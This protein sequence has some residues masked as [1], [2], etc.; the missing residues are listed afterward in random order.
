M[1]LVIFL[2]LKRAFETINRELLLSK[3]E[4][5]GLRNN[6]LNWFKSYLSNRSQRVKYK[7]SI[8]KELQI[9]HGV[10]QGTILGPIL[11]VLYINNI[12]KCVNECKINMFADDTI[13]YISGNDLNQMYITINRELAVI[14]NWL[15]EN[16]LS[17]NLNKTKYMLIGKNYKLSGLNAINFYV[18]INNYKLEQVKEMKYLGIIIDENLKFKQHCD[19]ILNKMS[20][21]VHFMRR[22][23]NNLTMNTKILLYKSIISPHI[24]YC[25]SILF[26]FNQNEIDKLQKL[27]NKSMRTILKCNKYTPIKTMLEVLNFMNVKQRIIFRTLD[28]IYK[29]KNKKTALYLCDKVKYVN[30]VHSHNTRQNGDFFIETAKT[31][32]LNNTLLY[33]GLNMFNALPT[34]IKNCENHNKFKKL[35]K[36]YVF[37]NYVQR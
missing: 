29:M 24:E 12:V 8:S 9:E 22:I 21:K 36:N 13:L 11:F 6:V 16:S 30:N 19:Y 33:K 5:I 31:S 35:L 17:L 26:N 20:K 18:E 4:E 10:P 14:N 27:Q 25:S 3:L 37:N 32:L 28:F 34:E 7:N 2:D 1:V 23:G 15:C